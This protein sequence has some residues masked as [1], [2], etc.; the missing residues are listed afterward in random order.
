[1]LLQDQMVT[2]LVLVMVIF[3]VVFFLCFCYSQSFI[4]TEHIQKNGQYMNE[5]NESL[6]EIAIHCKRD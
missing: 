3:V 4:I 5:I 2:V 1:M 6:K